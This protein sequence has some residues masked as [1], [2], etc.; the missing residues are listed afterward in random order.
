SAVAARLRLDRGDTAGALPLLV[1]A[2]RPD[3]PEATWAL[4]ARCVIEV[5]EAVSIDSD[6]P[7][8]EVCAEALRRSPDDPDLHNAVGILAARSGD[9]ATA[10]DRF[11]TA[12][13]LDPTRPEFRANLEQASR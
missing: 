12:V 9:L 2:A 11:A 13:R 3:D 5:A 7:L 6:V 8:A 10:R 1:V 4:T